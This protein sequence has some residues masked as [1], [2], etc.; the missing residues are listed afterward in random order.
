[1]LGTPEAPAGGMEEATTGVCDEAFAQLAKETLKNRPKT[2]FD[3]IS[4]PSVEGFPVDCYNFL[5]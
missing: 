4:T 1:M 5:Q 2:L 3:H